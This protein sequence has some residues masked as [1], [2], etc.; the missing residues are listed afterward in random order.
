MIFMYAL[1]SIV[2]SVQ[3]RFYNFKLNYELLNILTIVV[4]VSLSDNV[5]GNEYKLLH[6]DLLFLGSIFR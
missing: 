3:S 6:I 5:I 2:R 4:L 1:T